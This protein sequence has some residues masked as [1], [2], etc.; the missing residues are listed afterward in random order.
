MEEAIVYF[1]VFLII[2]MI[3]FFIVKRTCSPIKTFKAILLTIPAIATCG[4]AILIYKY[5]RNASYGN[6]IVPNNTKTSDYSNDVYFDEETKK[7]EPKRVGSAVKSG[8]GQTTYYDQYG[9]YMGQSL[10]NGFGEATFTDEN[11]DYAGQS[12]NN[13]LGDT[14]YEDKDGNVTLS[15]TNA[16]GEEVF[17]DGSKGVTDSLGNKRYR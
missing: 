10:D 11:G 6:G 12:F 13:G 2:F 15:H 1:I 17:D 4:I 5:F 3:F 7:D 14:Y 9:D 8:N 16:L